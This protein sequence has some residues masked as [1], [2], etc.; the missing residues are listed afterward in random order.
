MRP[1][2]GLVDIVRHVPVPRAGFPIGRITLRSTFCTIITRDVL[3]MVSGA[4]CCAGSDCAATA[5]IAN[6]I[7]RTTLPNLR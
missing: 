5:T 1:P 2:F 4:V 3:D 6:R 7:T